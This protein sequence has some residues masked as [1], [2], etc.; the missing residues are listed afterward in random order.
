MKALI[1]SERGGPEVLKIERIDAP[2]PSS[3]E[4]LV[5]VEAAGVNFADT[6]Q[7][8]GTYPLKL[9]TPYVAGMEAVG[10]IVDVGDD[11]EHSAPGDRV[12]VISFS[13]GGLTPNS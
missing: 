4:V 11:V 5:K 12:A 3:G 10:T 6:M 7:H 8:R 1:V 13:G 2:S 9:E